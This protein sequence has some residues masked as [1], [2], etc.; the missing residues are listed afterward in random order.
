VKLFFLLHY[1]P[2]LNPIEQVVAKLK[3]LLR[4]VAQTTVTNV[5]DAIAKALDAF[6]PTEC[7]NYF[8]NADYSTT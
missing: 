7:A 1:S 6:T 4:T 5:S 2:D 3:N 8:R